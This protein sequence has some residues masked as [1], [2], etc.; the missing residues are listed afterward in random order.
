MTI[1]AATNVL[2]NAPEIELGGEGGK[3]V[4][5]IGDMVN[6]TFGSSAGLHPI[7]EGSDVVF[8]I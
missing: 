6:V 8:A 7:V 5:R 4:A 2:V 1:D 3:Q